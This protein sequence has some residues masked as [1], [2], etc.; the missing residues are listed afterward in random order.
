MIRTTLAIVVL[1]SASFAFAGGGF[2][3]NPPAVADETLM[4]ST[5]QFKSLAL[6]AINNPDM[7]VRVNGKLAKPVLIDL[8]TKIMR[9]ESTDQTTIID[10]GQ[11]LDN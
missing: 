4:L 2:G 1:L 8:K 3:G 5:D 7:P 9:F 10:V 6:D 11:Q